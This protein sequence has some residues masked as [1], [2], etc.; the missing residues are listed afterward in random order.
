MVIFHS[1]VK[2]PEGRWFKQQKAWDCRILP[3]WPTSLV[4]WKYGVLPMK[5]SKASLDFDM[6]FWRGIRICNEYVIIVEFILVGNMVD[7]CWYWV[8]SHLIDM[9]P[10]WFLGSL[11]S[12][13]QALCNSRSFSGL[14]GRWISNSRKKSCK[15][16]RCSSP[17]QELT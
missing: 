5:Y 9:A 4:G 14:A 12:G 2:L 16:W 11:N 17:W 13:A 15:P 6:F 7:V 3:D 8:S 10:T 1:Y